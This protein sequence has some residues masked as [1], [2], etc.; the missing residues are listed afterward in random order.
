MPLPHALLSSKF[1]EHCTPP[2]IGSCK[3]CLVRSC[4]PSL[5]RYTLSGGVQDDL[6]QAL[7]GLHSVRT[8]SFQQ[9]TEH[10]SFNRTRPDRFDEQYKMVI[11]IVHLNNLQKFFKNQERKKCSEKLLVQFLKRNHKEIKKGKRIF[12]TT[13]QRQRCSI[14]LIVAELQRELISV[15]QT[16]HEFFPAVILT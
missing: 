13:S 3:I 9:G 1:V 14:K 15:Y 4:C 11:V 5:V 16:V 12:G 7:H 2:S 6:K 10:S 8:Q